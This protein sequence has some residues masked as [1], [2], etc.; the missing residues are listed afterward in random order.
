MWFDDLEVYD[1]LF[2]LYGDV[3]KFACFAFWFLVLRC[4]IYIFRITLCGFI[5][6]GVLLFVIL[7]IF[8]LFVNYLV[9]LCYLILLDCFG[10]NLWFWFSFCFDCLRWVFEVIA[11]FALRVLGM[12]VLNDW[13][14]LS[15][16]VVYFE[17]VGCCLFFVLM[18]WCV[19]ITDL[20]LLQ[21]RLFLL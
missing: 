19:I 2:T 17:V 8:C 18:V 1:L 9:V 21:L 11:F 5:I 14:V 15:N 20:S 4:C 6:C 13:F 12:I 3:L 10:Y 7:R 16:F